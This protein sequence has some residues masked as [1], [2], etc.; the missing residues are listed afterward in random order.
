MGTRTSGRDLESSKHSPRGFVL[1]HIRTGMNMAGPPLLTIKDVARRLSV[2]PSTVYALV[3]SGKLVSLR[4]GIG[5]GTIRFKE[6]DLERFLDA[7]SSAPP[8]PSAPEHEAISAETLAN[9]TC[10][11]LQFAQQMFRI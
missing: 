5:R 3:E 7:C 11:T 8:R 6:S 4:I 10:D 2:A 1:L 9:L